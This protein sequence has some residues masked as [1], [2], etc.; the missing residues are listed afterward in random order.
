MKK[1]TEEYIQ[2][3]T[4]FIHKIDFFKKESTPERRLAI[5]QTT[6]EDAVSTTQHRSD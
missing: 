6:W 4:V 2:Y 3:D 5:S 1:V